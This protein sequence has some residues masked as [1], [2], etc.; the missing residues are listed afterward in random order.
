MGLGKRNVVT[1]DLK[2][3]VTLILGEPKI[4]KT[5]LAKNIIKEIT[6]TSDKILM[7]E[8][9]GETGFE[10]IDGLIYEAPQNQS[11]LDITIDEFLE[12]GHDFEFFAIDTINELCKFT[13]EQTLKDHHRQNG[14][15]AS[16]VNACFGGYGS[17]AK[18][19]YGISESIIDRFK[20]SPYGLIL[21]GHNKVKSET[22][23]GGEKY[24]V[25]TSDLFSNYY[26]A[27]S[28]KATLICNII[29]DTS[30]EEDKLNGSVRMMY[31]RSNNFVKAGS[32]FE[33][34]QEKAEYGAKNFVEV[35]KNAVRDSKDDATRDTD[36]F[37][38]VKN[39]PSESM[40]NSKTLD[41]Y[42]KEITDTTLEVQDEIEGANSKI[43][44]VLK[45]NDINNPNKI[46]DK[47]LAKK[48]LAELS[49]LV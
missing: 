18:H 22:K 29:T 35:F 17:G 46:Q 21:I 12:G 6:G 25:V 24:D 7:A 44:K 45:D 31:F 5:T 33:V 9:G 10:A 11:E 20:L 42:I 26:S 40:T 49:K 38:K 3:Y 43:M 15:V 39:T 14:E 32:R 41:E 2:N 19:S 27:F 8:L 34:I 47:E 4:G 16:S 48:V 37:D 23:E 13:D 36:K 30:V 1:P 28:K